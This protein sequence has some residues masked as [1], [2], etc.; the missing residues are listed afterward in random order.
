MLRRSGTAAGGT[1]T[2]PKA[3][4]PSARKGGRFSRLT[5]RSGRKQVTRKQV[6][7]VT[8][9]PSAPRRSLGSHILRRLVGTV[10][11][12]AFAVCA[13]V[14][15][16]LTMTAS[17]A[18]V[19]IAHTNL[20]PGRSIRLYLD[21]PSVREAALQI[22]GNILIGVPFGLLLPV[23]TPRARGL[24]RVLVITTVVVFAIELAQHFFVEGRS[25]DVD[26]LILAAGGAVLGYV[27]VGRYLSLRI[28]RGHRHWWQ[29]LLGTRRRFAA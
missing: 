4:D 29:R 15:L 11:L 7:P 20:H 17:P 23:I 2:K 28:H 25:F 14:V 27:P 8:D 22:G 19:G 5:T 6:A 24:L 26:D 10:A 13:A 9:V 3:A 18:S 12:L 21:Q 16:K 1:L